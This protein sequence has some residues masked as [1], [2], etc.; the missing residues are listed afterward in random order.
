MKREDGAQRVVNLALGIE[1][2]ACSLLQPEEEGLAITT[3]TIIINIIY[4]ARQQPPQLDVPPK[5]K[6]QGAIQHSPIFGQ[7]LGEVETKTL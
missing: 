1:F 6:G 4:G 5:G 2:E 3:G 7:G